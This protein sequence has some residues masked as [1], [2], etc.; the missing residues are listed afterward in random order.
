[1]NFT[2]AKTQTMV[3]TSVIIADGLFFAYFIFFLFFSNIVLAD[4]PVSISDTNNPAI[5]QLISEFNK[6]NLNPV[7]AQ[8]VIRKHLS[9]VGHTITLNNDSVQIFQYTDNDT[10]INEATLMMQKYA[11]STRST[12]WKKDIHMYANSNTVIFYLGKNINILNS[13]DSNTGYTVINLAKR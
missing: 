13:L 5:S 10:A 11:D 2:P 12:R 3:L 1:M 9:G 6:S 7:L 8:T 4:T